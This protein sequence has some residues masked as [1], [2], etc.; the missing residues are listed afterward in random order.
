MNPLVDAYFNKVQKWQKELE[1]LRKI[2]QDCQLT[3]ELK[4]KNPCYTFQQSNI[5]IIHSFK[6]YC[7]IS[8]FKGALLN[9]AHNILIQITENVQAVRQMRFTSLKEIMALEPI[10]KSYIYE[11]I[12]I[13]K[14][15]L[16]VQ[17]IKH[18]DITFTEELQTK[19]DEM[20]AFKKAFE[21]LTPGRQRA[22]HLYFSAP[23]QSKTRTSRVENYIQ[24]I[25][26]GKGLNDCTCG[27]SQK[28][29]SCD[30]SHK[31]IGGKP[32]F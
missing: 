16:Q 5:V 21:A 20:P 18:T 1:Q 24:Q 11:A 32:L 14:A 22:Y 7:G 30:G 3:E 31:N 27:L 10:L 4:W 15:G 29:P 2:V 6:E 23:K 28:M 9:D 12:E 17:F 8:F 19:L 13:E 25:L 26:N